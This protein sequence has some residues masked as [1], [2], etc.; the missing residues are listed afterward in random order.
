MSRT[1]LI[2]PTIIVKMTRS[3]MTMYFVLEDEVVDEAAAAAG[4]VVTAAPDVWLRLHVVFTF[5]N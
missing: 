4:V 2:P 5:P 1:V 3:A